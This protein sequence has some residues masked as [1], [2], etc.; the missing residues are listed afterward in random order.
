MFDPSKSMNE[1]ATAD[2]KF[3]EFLVH[4]GF[5]FSANNPITRLVTFN[6]VVK[7][8]KLDADAFLAEYEAWAAG[9]E[10]E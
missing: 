5:P 2:P 9:S 4:K 10:T 3:A 1:I 6:D 8:K 7:F